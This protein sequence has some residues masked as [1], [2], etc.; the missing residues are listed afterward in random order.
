MSATVPFEIG[1]FTFGELT[2]NAAELAQQYWDQNGCEVA[3]GVEMGEGRHDA[4]RMAV[5]PELNWRMQET[6]V[7]CGALVDQKKKPRG[8][9]NSSQPKHTR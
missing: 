3:S 8:S 1:I 7:H 4:V 5:Q 2:R 9:D 6:V